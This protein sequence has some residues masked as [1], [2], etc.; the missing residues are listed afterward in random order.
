MPMMARIGRAARAKG[1]VSDEQATAWVA[2]QA[3]RAR[4]GRLFMAVPL[5]LAA[6]RRP[7]AGRRA[8]PTTAGEPARETA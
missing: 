1:G 8:T 4:A 2:E 5:F 7:S 6:G 3:E